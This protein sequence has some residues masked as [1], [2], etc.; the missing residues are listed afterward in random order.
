MI[1]WTN[2]GWKLLDKVVEIVIPSKFV[3]FLNQTFYQNSFFIFNY[4]SFI[5]LFSG[6]L[7]YL[8]FSNRFKT[9]ILINIIF[10]IVEF[11]LGIG[12][13]PLFVEETKD[14]VWDVI[15]SIA[16]FKITQAI[17]FRIKKR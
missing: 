2:S 12:R 4:W 8:I 16:G 11:A 7:F 1:D 6:V 9:W 17:I 3:T 13:N 14:I 10:E 5:H 15:L